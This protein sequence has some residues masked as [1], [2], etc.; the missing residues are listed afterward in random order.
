MNSFVGNI[1]YLEV[2]F[3]NFIVGII[4]IIIISFSYGVVGFIVGVYIVVDVG[5]FIIVL[6]G[7]VFLFWLIR[8]FGERVVYCGVYGVS[9]VIV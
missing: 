9:I 6:V 4:N 2:F 1:I 3:Y 7:F 8:F 5:L